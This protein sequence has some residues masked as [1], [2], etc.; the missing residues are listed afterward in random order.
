MDSHKSIGLTKTF[1]YQVGVRRTF[2]ISQQQAWSLITGKEGLNA[3][4]GGGENIILKL[5]HQYRTMV[6]TGE[7]RIVKP[8][9]NSALLGKKRDGNDL[10]PYKFESYPKKI[11]KRPLVF[12]RNILPISK[13]EKK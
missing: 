6:G 2:S 4:L 8:L 11:I 12:I 1:G 7:I 10:L 13:E 9:L 3:W 5:G